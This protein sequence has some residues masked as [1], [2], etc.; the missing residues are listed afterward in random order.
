MNEVNGLLTTKDR[1]IADLINQAH[2]TRRPRK[3]RRH[4]RSEGINNCQAPNLA[5]IEEHT[6][7][8]GHQ[9]HYRG[10][11]RQLRDLGTFQH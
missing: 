11:N 2:A 3:R 1:Q 5:T 4:H 10:R 8:A 7:A 9:T 6:R